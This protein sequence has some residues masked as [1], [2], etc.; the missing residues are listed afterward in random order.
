MALEVDY[1]PIAVAEGANVDSQATFAGSAYQVNGVST[2][3]A[4]SSG[5]SKMWR[6]SSMFAAALANLISAELQT[7]VL[8]D[9]NVPALQSLIQQT[10]VS[11]ANGA[12]A[13]ATPVAFA[14]A[15]AFNGTESRTFE[16]TLTGNNTSATFDATDAATYIFMFRQ[17][18]TGG[19]V[20]TFPPN[21]PLPPVAAAANSVT[22]YQVYVDSTGVA[23]LLSG[24]NV[25]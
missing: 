8:D 11:L 12:S 25:S 22:I 1:L 20:F 4:S 21:L 10:I 18:A 23:R 19:R 9:G 2:G 17:D 15:M 7:N 13:G 3:K 6:Q 14:P 16:T 5:A 24:P